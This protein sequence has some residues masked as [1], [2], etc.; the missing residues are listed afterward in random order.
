MDLFVRQR[1]YKRAVWSLEFLQ[2]EVRIDAFQ[3][4]SDLIAIATAIWHVL[5]KSVN[6]RPERF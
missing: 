6:L 2:L 1:G 4:G 3:G 5:A